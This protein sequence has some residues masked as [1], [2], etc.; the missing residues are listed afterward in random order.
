MDAVT[1]RVRKDSENRQKKLIKRQK[2]KSLIKGRENQKKTGAL[3]AKM[4]VLSRSVMSDF[5]TPRTV[6]HQ[7]L[8]SMVIL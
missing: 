4:Y 6:A 2:K 7:V 1:C 5:V 8:L 3:K